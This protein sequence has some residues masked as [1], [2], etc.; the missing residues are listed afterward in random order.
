MISL[1]GRC[2]AAAPLQKRKKIS[3]DLL[4]PRA[5]KSVRVCPRI[6][7]DELQ[8]AESGRICEYRNPVDQ[9]R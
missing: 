4:R 1:G 5:I 2:Y 7:I 8:H 3:L 9:I 6:R